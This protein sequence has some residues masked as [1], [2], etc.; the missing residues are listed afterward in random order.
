MV[1]GAD[2]SGADV[3]RDGGPA[4][5]QGNIYSMG[6]QQQINAGPQGGLSLRDYFA[7][8]APAEYLAVMAAKV[9]E[10]GDNE[11]EV[12]TIMA[13]AAFMYAD[14]MLAEREKS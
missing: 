1:P 14:A 10:A 3:K 12:A 6:N 4:F 13:A 2:R 5:P 8:H 11:T 9:Q 7:I